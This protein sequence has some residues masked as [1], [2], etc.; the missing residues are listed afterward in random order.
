MPELSRWL[1]H[2]SEHRFVNSTGTTLA[3][4]YKSGCCWYATLSHSSTSGRFKHLSEAKSVAESLVIRGDK[5]E[6]SR[7][8]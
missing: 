7:G 6:I 2:G 4:V 1:D 3:R 5:R 8:H